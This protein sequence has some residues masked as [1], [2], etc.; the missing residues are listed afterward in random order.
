MHYLFAAPATEPLPP[1]PAGLRLVATQDAPV[2]ESP[3]LLKKFRIVRHGDVVISSGKSDRYTGDTMVAIWPAGYVNLSHFTVVGGWGG[4]G[5]DSLSGVVETTVKE[6]VVF[7]EEREGKQS[8]ADSSKSCRLK[9]HMRSITSAS[10]VNPDFNAIDSMSM[11]L[12]TTSSCAKRLNNTAPSVPSSGLWR[13]DIAAERLMNADLIGFNPEAFRKTGASLLYMMNDSNLIQLSQMNVAFMPQNVTNV[14]SDWEAVVRIQDLDLLLYNPDNIFLCEDVSGE[15]QCV[16]HLQLNPFVLLPHMFFFGVVPALD[17]P[18]RSCIVKVAFVEVFLLLAVLST[19]V[20]LLGLLWWAFDIAWLLFNVLV[21]ERT[22]GCSEEQLAL[23]KRLGIEPRKRQDAEGGAAS[24][25]ESAE[26]G[27]PGFAAATAASAAAGNSE[28]Q[29]QRLGEVPLAEVSPSAAGPGL[30]DVCLYMFYSLIFCLAG[31]KIFEGLAKDPESSAARSFLCVAPVLTHILLA[32][33]AVEVFLLWECHRESLDNGVLLMMHEQQIYPFYAGCAL[34]CVIAANAF[35]LLLVDSITPAVLYLGAAGIPLLYAFTWTM[36]LLSC[37]Q[38]TVDYARGEDCHVHLQK[39]GESTAPLFSMA[40]LRIRDT[41]A[42][43]MLCF[44]FVGVGMI[45]ACVVALNVETVEGSFHDCSISAGVWLTKDPFHSEESLRTIIIG[46]EVDRFELMCLTAKDGEVRDVHLRVLHPSGNIDQRRFDKV[47]EPNGVTLTVEVPLEPNTVLP[48]VIEIPVLA[49]KERIYRFTVVRIA[50]DV[51]AELAAPILGSVEGKTASVVH[52]FREARR[53][54]DIAKHDRW[55]LPQVVREDMTMMLRTSQTVCAP[56]MNKLSGLRAPQFAS[57]S[58]EDI[59]PQDGTFGHSCRMF[60][61]VTDG[62]VFQRRPQLVRIDQVA[63]RSENHSIWSWLFGDVVK[64]QFCEG[65]TENCILASEDVNLRDQSELSRHF[66]VRLDAHMRRLRDFAVI[67]SVIG[68]LRMVVSRGWLTRVVEERVDFRFTTPPLTVTLNESCFMIPDESVPRGVVVGFQP[69]FHRYSVP[70]FQNCFSVNLEKRYQQD[71]TVVASYVEDNHL[72]AQ[73]RTLAITVQRL[74]DAACRPW[75]LQYG[76][77]LEVSKE[78]D[79]VADYIFV[80]RPAAVFDAIYVGNLLWAEKLVAKFPSVMDS[81]VT[82]D[83]L[84]GVAAMSGH[85]SVV[86]AMLQHDG[87][88]DFQNGDGLTPALLA[89]KG[90]HIPVLEALLAAGANVSKVV[91]N[92]HGSEANALSVAVDAGRSDMLAFILDREQAGQDGDVEKEGD[93]QSSISCKLPASSAFSAP[94]LLV[95]AELAGHGSVLDTIV[96]KCHTDVNLLVHGKTPLAWAL[97]RSAPSSIVRR[98]VGLGANPN[99]LPGQELSP[100]Q[101]AA[102]R[103]HFTAM[104]FLLAHGALPD[105]KV[106]NWTASD[107]VAA[108]GAAGQR[109]ALAILR[110]ATYYAHLAEGIEA[111][112]SATEATI[113]PDDALWAYRSQIELCTELEAKV[114]S[115]PRQTPAEPSNFAGNEERYADI[116]RARARVDPPVRA[117]LTTTIPAVTPEMVDGIATGQPRVAAKLSSIH[118]SSSERQDQFEEESNMEASA[119]VDRALG[120]PDRN[121]GAISPSAVANMAQEPGTSASIDA[122][123]NASAN[124]S[125]GATKPVQLQ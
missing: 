90:G 121:E 78:L 18:E 42:M 51:E 89:V 49:R 57:M 15:P 107:I 19:S 109:K 4:G 24:E 11:Y 118:G 13:L 34:V 39:V 3:F 79:H 65:A 80:A 77:R 70:G 64:V 116:T 67:E 96:A 50:D 82:G 26:A 30:G 115:T 86:A 38:L 16:S 85:V 112:Q 101:A 1:P 88:L 69:D 108:G 76:H 37:T 75:C 125:S 93:A 114:S 95:R 35:I 102:C 91:T 21:R 36:S 124:S 9:S 72:P 110:N 52:T 6:S 92:E 122:S 117:D 10:I 111:A 22:D 81:P 61:P 105:L 46:E 123:S 40:S 87:R 41:F 5:D 33:I 27:G 28:A 104:R 58:C 25:D 83:S 56:I 20:G 43:V 74:D 120:L 8:D 45:S 53:L 2:F 17:D 14:A 119:I 66:V 32:V 100:L 68:R 60:R 48:T 103:R 55:Y 59:C 113:D 63:L 29:P 97:T 71:F 54:D 73:E 94:A 84:L 106:N 98:L 47:S 44:T 12:S 62:C 7:S 23:L 31:E 99:G